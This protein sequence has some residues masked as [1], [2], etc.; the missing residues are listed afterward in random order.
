M[1]PFAVRLPEP[2]D[3]DFIQLHVPN[4]H[5][6]IHLPFLGPPQPLIDVRQEYFLILLPQ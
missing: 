1:V 5:Y 6:R 3:D 2:Y 4:P